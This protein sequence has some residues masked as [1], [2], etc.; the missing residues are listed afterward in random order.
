MNQYSRSYRDYHRTQHI[1]TAKVIAG[2]ALLLALIIFTGF[3]PNPKMIDWQKQQCADWG[4]AYNVQATFN[5]TTHR[6]DL[7][8]PVTINK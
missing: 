7:N 3:Q 5:T 2:S 6:C 1:S 8:P 4:Q